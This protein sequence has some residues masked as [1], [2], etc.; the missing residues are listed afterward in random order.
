MG[1]KSGRSNNAADAPKAMAFL[2]KVPMHC[3]CDGCSD[4]IRAAVKGLTLRC[5]SILSL[6]QSALST[7]GKRA[8][9]ATADPER[10]RRCLRKATG[11]LL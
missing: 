7:K 5:D 6:D 3:R 4:K 8:V 2:L 10:L 1:K 9:V 11:G